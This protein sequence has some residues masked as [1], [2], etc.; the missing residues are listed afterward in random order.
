MKKL[1]LILLILLVVYASSIGPITKPEG[2]DT[3]E[4][5]FSYYQS[6]VNSGRG[7]TIP[8]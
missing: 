5:Q 7:I 6:I 8:K 4:G 2:Y 3:F 1:L